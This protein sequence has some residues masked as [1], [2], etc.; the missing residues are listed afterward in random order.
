MLKRLVGLS[1]LL[2]AVGCGSSTPPPGGGA[3]T[4][5]DDVIVTPPDD[6]PAIPTDQDTDGDGVPDLRDLFPHNPDEWADSDGDG[7]GDN[8]D[9]LPNDPTETTDV[10][11]DGIGDNAQRLFA[12]ADEPAG[13]NCPYGG[14]ATR[15]GLDANGDGV[16]QSAEVLTER[17]IY[18]CDAQHVTIGG[19]ITGLPA[20][21][22][23]GIALL[24]NAGGAGVI[25]TTGSF[26]LPTVVYTGSDY[27]V[28]IAVQPTTRY[29]EPTPGSSTNGVVGTTPITDISLSCYRNGEVIT[30]LGRAS[31]GVAFDRN[32][33]LITGDNVLRVTKPDGTFTTITGESGFGLVSDLTTDAAGNIYAAD[34]IMSVVR[35]VAPDGTVTILAGGL[36][37]PAQHLDATGT[38]ARFANV[39]ALAADNLGRVYA[40]DANRLRRIA[41]DGAVT[42]LATDMHFASNPVSPV[43]RAITDI[44][45]DPRTNDLYMA[46]DTDD[47]LKIIYAGGGAALVAISYGNA[48]YAS[49]KGL[50][51]D[52]V[53]NLYISDTQNS[54]LRVRRISPAARNSVYVNVNTNLSEPVLQ[55]LS[56][57]A[58]GAFVNGVGTTARFSSNIGR[59]AVDANGHAYVS[60]VGNAAIRKV[61]FVVGDIPPPPPPTQ[62]PLGANDLFVLGDELIQPFTNTPAAL[63]M[64]SVFN[65]SWD[66]TKYGA[67]PSRGA[68]FDFA[69]ELCRGTERCETPGDAMQ[70]LVYRTRETAA[71]YGVMSAWADLRRTP[72]WG[73][74]APSSTACTGSEEL[75]NLH[76]VTLTVPVLDASRVPDEVEQSVWRA[77]VAPVNLL[78]TLSLL[79]GLVDELVAG[80]PGYGTDAITA[81]KGL[82]ADTPLSRGVETALLFLEAKRLADLQRRGQ[83]LTGYQ[84][85][86]AQDLC[87]EMIAQQ[88]SAIIEIGND[89]RAFHAENEPPK[90][91][92]GQYTAPAPTAAHE[93]ALIAL[94]PRSARTEDISDATTVAFRLLTAVGRSQRDIS[95]REAVIP[96]FGAG[97]PLAG[98]VAAIAAGTAF[99]GVI[100]SALGVDL[101]FDA[102]S[103]ALA[104]LSASAHGTNGLVGPTALGAAAI[105]SSPAMRAIADGDA[106][107]DL[108]NGFA[109]LLDVYE[110]LEVTLGD[111]TDES[112][113][114]GYNRLF[115]GGD[116]Q[117]LFG[118][119]NLVAD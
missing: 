36:G 82:G 3:Q 12:T 66:E 40:I 93:R 53:G 23:D 96:D 117:M 47:D 68:I 24:E 103:F 19:S 7:I 69:W 33:N 34:S 85:M 111:L 89:F 9:A 99:A 51:I 84:L 94:M 8:S 41:A 15:F 74:H 116:H 11:G 22:A 92:G 1:V 13:A 119:A 78:R 63:E 76:C 32:G 71:W 79:Q 26:E 14:M 59:L 5:D 37:A 31:A 4:P 57:G 109:K 95:S 45:V 83:T 18:A 16:L 52:A 80:D 100:S 112:T 81:L 65:T 46:D 39:T 70:N 64:E 86:F 50:D 67:R 58:L 48:Q 30:Y 55:V 49:I 90:I 102:S 35:K 87:S 72:G 28:T 113:G 29:C 38:S 56:S 62:I 91:K 114:H 97:L 10:N 98:S 21:D 101:R 75:Q 73:R 44:A 43:S 2:V 61:H 17:T 106:Y 107:Y 54:V 108:L 27:H 20:N 25:T 118:M 105:A 6:D 42:T 110:R 115:P 60:D 104:S 77:A 88:R